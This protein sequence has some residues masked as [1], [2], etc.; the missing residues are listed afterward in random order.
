MSVVLS[1]QHAMRMFYIVISGMSG[2]TRICKF[3][4]KRYDCQKKRVIEHKMDVLIFCRTF[5]SN[6]S[7]SRRN[8][9]HVIKNMFVFM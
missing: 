2:C 6:I 7:R 1:I 5:V 9:R 8:E 3:T 4:H